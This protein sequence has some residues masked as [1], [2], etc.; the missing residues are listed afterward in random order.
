MRVRWARRVAVLA[1]MMALAGA[2]P[3]ASA[4][5][6]YRVIVNSGNPQDSVDRKFLAEGFLKKAAEWPDGTPI[7]PVDLAGDSPVRR[8]FSEEVMGRSVA[9]IKSYWQQ[10]IFSGRGVP[11]PELE[12]DEEV[13]KFVARRR[14]AVGYVSMGGEVSGVKVV[15]VR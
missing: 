3:G 1:A 9:A 12:T 8:R 10:L 7:A 5:P 2:R 13:V 14:G 15:G 4:P 11:P 6:A